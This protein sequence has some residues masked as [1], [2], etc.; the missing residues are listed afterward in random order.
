[1]YTL[2]QVHVKRHV[3]G[4]DS[5]LSNE[6]GSN[7]HIFKNLKAP[8]VRKGKLVVVDLA[9]SERIDK[10]GMCSQPIQIMSA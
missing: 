8:I 10:S 7:S 9:G 3:K 1:M 4:R 2:L 6:N 5:T